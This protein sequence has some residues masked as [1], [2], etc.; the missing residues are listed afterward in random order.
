MV[1]KV[2]KASN[3]FD[4]FVVPK[5]LN[6]CLYAIMASKRPKVKMVSFFL[7]Y[8]ILCF[9]FQNYLMHYGLFINL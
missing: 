5:T 4:M 1:S 2:K 6:Q 8:R 9:Y 7:K 3:I